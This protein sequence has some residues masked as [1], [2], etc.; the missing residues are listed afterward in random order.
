[1]RTRVSSFSKNASRLLL[2][3]AALLTLCASTA[4]AGAPSDPTSSTSLCSA[5]VPKMS[6][7]EPPGSAAGSA[8]GAVGSGSV[9][10]DGGG[11]AGGGVAGGGGS[12]VGVPAPGAG[13][14]ATRA[15]TGN[16]ARAPS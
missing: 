9:G 3:V 2:R 5:S 1:M 13:A 7:I 12:G 11:S 8:A 6:S 16:T 15:S 4:V 10:S 14:G